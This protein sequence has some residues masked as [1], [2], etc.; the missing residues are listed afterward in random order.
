M[1]YAET[2]FWTLTPRQL[3]LHFKGFNERQKRE[4]QGRAWQ[5]W[6]TARLVHIDPKKAPK[7]EAL[8]EVKPARKPQSTE[9]MLAIAR[10]ITA[11]QR[12]KLN[13]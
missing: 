6:V 4:H 2:L 10:A 13:R 7:L 1:G 3:V 5:A 8:M 9:T 11:A 12:Q